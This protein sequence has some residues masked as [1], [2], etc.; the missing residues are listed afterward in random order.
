VVLAVVQ[1]AAGWV[2]ALDGVLI[3]AGDARFL[4][5]GATVSTIVFAPIAVLVMVADLGLDALWVGV[6]VWV[7]ARLVLLVWRARSDAWAV[8]GATR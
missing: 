6:G 1:P 7:L 5:V 4:A 8:A 3:G 2:F